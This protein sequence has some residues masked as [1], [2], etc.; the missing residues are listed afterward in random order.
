MARGIEGSECHVG[1]A[2]LD[3]GRAACVRGDKPL[4]RQAKSMSTALPLSAKGE[5]R[6]GGQQAGTHA[7]VRVDTRVCVSPTPQPPTHLVAK[8]VVTDRPSVTR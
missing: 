3:M 5:R 2:R 4:S 7:R 6:A 1:L 8:E